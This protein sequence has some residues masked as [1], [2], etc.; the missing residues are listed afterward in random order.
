MSKI[1]EQKPDDKSSRQ[2]IS[3]LLRGPEPIY[4]RIKN[5][6]ITKIKS[7]DWPPGFRIPSENKLVGS[8][9]VS[10]MTV[11]RALRELSQEGYLARV[12]GAGTF[13]KELPQ[14]SSL[15]ELRNIADEIKARGHKHT[16]RIVQSAEI[17]APGDLAGRMEIAAGESVFHII[18]V[19]FSDDVPVQLEDRYVNTFVVPEFLQQNF[20][21]LTPTEYLVSLIPV[22]ELEHR[23]QAIMPNPEQMELL[24]LPAHEPCLALHRRSWFRG[25]VVTTAVLTYPASR[26]ELYSRYATTPAGGMGPSS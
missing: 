15:L 9:K 14:Q 3:E 8:F 6:I 2:S 11:N 7:G 20:V 24:D 18:M 5:Q 4:R 23:V 1:V 26:Y 16:V 17:A 22:D 10:R 13:V 12:Q 21:E 25:Q 19:H